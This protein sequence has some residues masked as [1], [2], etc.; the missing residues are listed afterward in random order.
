MSWGCWGCTGGANSSW[1]KLHLQVIT[2][3][4]EGSTWHEQI[5]PQP[6][7][8]LKKHTVVF[9]LLCFVWPLSLSKRKNQTPAGLFAPRAWTSW[10]AGQFHWQPLLEI[11]TAPS[12]SLWVTCSR[13]LSFSEYILAPRHPCFACVPLQMHKSLVRSQSAF[14]NSK[15]S[16]H[17]GSKGLYRAGRVTVQEWTQSTK[18][19]QQEML[20]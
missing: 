5:A 4:R 3:E 7:T 14:R 20:F 9:L 17:L 18:V 15:H 12:S 1:E 2:P 11:Y 8:Q 13:Q 16:A 10:P 19:E 6:S